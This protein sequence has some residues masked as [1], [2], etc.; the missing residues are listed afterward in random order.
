MASTPYEF[1]AFLMP[2]APGRSW[3]YTGLTAGQVG[4]N[5]AANKAVVTDVSAYIDVDNTVKFAVVMT[6]SSQKSWWYPD[7][8]AGQVGQNLA[9]NKAVRDGR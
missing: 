8:T 3:W 5:L 6:A 4:Q 7:L 1:G 2:A 9:A